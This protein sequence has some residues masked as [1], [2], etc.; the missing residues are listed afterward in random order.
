MGIVERY[1]LM[2]FGAVLTLLGVYLFARRDSAGSN[3]L[4]LFGAEVELSAPSLVIVV[5]GVGLIGLPLYLGSNQLERFPSVGAGLQ[6]DF[7]FGTEELIADLGYA[8]SD[9]SPTTLDDTGPGPEWRPLA[10]ELL[11]MGYTQEYVELLQYIA[12]DPRA[13]STMDPYELAQLIAD[14]YSSLS[15]PGDEPFVSRPD[16]A[17]DVIA[18]AREMVAY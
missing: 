5:L 9:D 17:A 3:R 12:P 15:M 1:F 4:K 16:D 14:T 8:L 6:D 18:T 11:D 10:V 13:L 7:E 2:F